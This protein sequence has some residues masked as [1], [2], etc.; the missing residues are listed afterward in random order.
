M[1]G[2]KDLLRK[3]LGG[4]AFGGGMLVSGLLA[5]NVS[6]TVNTLSSGELISPDYA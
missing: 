1:P 6:G 3:F 4:M 2:I 5:V